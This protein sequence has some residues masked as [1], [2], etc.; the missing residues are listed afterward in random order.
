MS[1]KKE[2]T[3]LVFLIVILITCIV[4]VVFMNQKNKESYTPKVI[5]DK[6]HII[7]IGG[8]IDIEKKLVNISKNQEDN[9]GTYSIH[10]FNPILDSSNM[11]PKDWI[12]IGK[13]ITSV[14][15][16]YDSFIII[17]GADT[18]TYTASSLAFMFENLSKPIVIIGI[19]K[20]EKNESNDILSSLLYA[21][22]YNIP[23]V[24]VISND[25]IY[26]ACCTVKNSSNN[27][28]SPSLPPLGE[29]TG[30]NI[31]IDYEIILK[32]PTAGT[33]FKPFNTK[34]RVVVIKL[35]PGITSEYIRTVLGAYPVHGIVFELYGV[36]HSPTDKLFLEALEDLSSKMVLM[37]GV[38]HSSNNE[39]DTE[40]E[41]RGVFTGLNMSTETALSK[42]YY[43]ITTTDNYEQAATMIQQPLRGELVVDLNV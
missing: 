27:I 28:I 16:Q 3:Y 26:R 37:I 36:G 2:K 13:Y 20:N 10:A 4:L 30:E 22:Q 15:D 12:K 34:I 18:V 23:E 14:Y 39:R 17:H 41:K 7:H 19:S 43:L 29:I 6:I 32:P 8:T 40:L 1:S 11:K 21:S 9:I 31:D 24:V 25:K 5:N 38:N 42:L 35:F 33:I